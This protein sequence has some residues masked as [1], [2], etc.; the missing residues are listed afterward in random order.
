MRRIDL[1]N[2]RLAIVLILWNYNFS[3]F[4]MEIL[5]GTQQQPRTKTKSESLTCQRWAVSTKLSKLLDRNCHCIRLRSRNAN[6]SVNYCSVFFL[7]MPFIRQPIIDFCLFRCH[8]SIFIASSLSIFSSRNTIARLPASFLSSISRDFAPVQPTEWARCV[9]ERC[10]KYDISP[11]WTCALNEKL[12]SFVCSADGK[13]PFY[14]VACE[15]L[16]CLRFRFHSKEILLR[17]P[18]LLTNCVRCV[19]QTVFFFGFICLDLNAFSF[20]SVVLSVTEPSFRTI[21]SPRRIYAITPSEKWK[22]YSREK[23]LFS[24]GWRFA[25]AGL[26][27]LSRKKRILFI[28]ESIGSGRW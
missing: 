10:E 23:K 27:E 7:S 4:R 19:L 6:K 15:F 24:C 25:H 14:I 26:F 1:H 21:L 20:I 22:K 3:Y 11:H 12:P 13:L 8:H 16:R 9:D 28:A 18:P 5:V 2:C 17:P